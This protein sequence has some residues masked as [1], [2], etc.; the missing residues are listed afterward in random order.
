MIDS[1]QPDR[2]APPEVGKATPVAMLPRLL[3]MVECDAGSD[4]GGKAEDWRTGEADETRQPRRQ[5]GRQGVPP[6][7]WTRATTVVIWGG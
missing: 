7:R 5:D 6:F 3:E 4:Q 2:G 1:S